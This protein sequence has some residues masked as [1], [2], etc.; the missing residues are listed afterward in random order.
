[1]AITI[2]GSVTGAAITGLTSPT[3]TLTQDYMQGNGKQSIVTSLGG[4]QTGV[5]VHSAADPFTVAVY[6]PLAYRFLNFV[7]STVARRAPKNTWKV[8]IKKG[9]TYLAGQPKDVAMT[10]FLIDLPAGCEIADVANIRAMLSCGI[11]V[12]YGQAD[13][14]SVSAITNSI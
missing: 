7:S 10:S 12:I 14:I 3:Y 8:V 9:V 1:M 4:T 11:G 13:N 5:T 6:K 2:V